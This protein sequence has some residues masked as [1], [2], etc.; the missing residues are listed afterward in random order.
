MGLFVG[1]LALSARRNVAAGSLWHAE[2][3]YLLLSSGCFCQEN[4][5]VEPSS[6][7][8]RVHLAV[9]MSNLPASCAVVE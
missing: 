4:S 6:V 5:R 8:S 7:P 9:S 1:I 2:H 3:L